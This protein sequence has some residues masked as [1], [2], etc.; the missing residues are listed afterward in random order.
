MSDFLVDTN[1]LVYAIDTKE[2][3]KQAV[4]NAWLSGIENDGN[5]YFLSLQNI[6]EFISVCLK[7]KIEAKK[8]H[9]AAENFANGFHLIQDNYTDSV[10]ALKISAEHRIPFWDALLIATMERNGVTS[11]VTEDTGSFERHPE[12]TA[13]NIFEGFLG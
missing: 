10:L 11:I 6:R 13:A 12:I 8:I 1:I 7:K 4:T 5:R 2:P 9:E 3:E